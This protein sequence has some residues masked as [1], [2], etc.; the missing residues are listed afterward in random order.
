MSRLKDDIR[1]LRELVQSVPDNA[2]FS[3]E[4]VWLVPI[5]TVEQLTRILN[6]CEKMGAALDAIDHELGRPQGLG[7]PAPIVNA[8]DICMAA[9]KEARGE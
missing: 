3:K 8:S 5:P 1:A 9:L 2:H 7:L 4:R 6:A